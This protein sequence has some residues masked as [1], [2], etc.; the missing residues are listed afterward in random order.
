M[1]ASSRLAY[2][3]GTATVKRAAPAQDPGRG[4]RG[5]EWDGSPENKGKSGRTK[6]PNSRLILASPTSQSLDVFSDDNNS[7]FNRSSPTSV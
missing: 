2:T 6:L 5:R 4:A 3:Q 1:T 7:A